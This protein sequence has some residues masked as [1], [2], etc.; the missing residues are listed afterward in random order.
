MPLP[1]EIPPNP[2]RRSKFLHSHFTDG[3]TEGLTIRTLPVRQSRPIAGQSQSSDERPCLLPGGPSACASVREQSLGASQGPVQA[4]SGGKAAQKA[5]MRCE[6]LIPGNIHTG[7][8]SH[9][10]ERERIAWKSVLRPQGQSNVDGVTETTDTYSSQ[11]WMS[12][13]KIKELAG[14]FLRALSP[15]LADGCF[16]PVSPRAPPSVHVCVLIFPF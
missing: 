8:H 10:W 9:V 4:G 12:Q 1:S 11:T 2:S 6:Q 15:C 14:L 16:L 13:F 5:W 3:A 7:L